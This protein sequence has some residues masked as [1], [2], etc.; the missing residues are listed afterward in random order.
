MPQ[1]TIHVGGRER[2]E[3]AISKATPLGALGTEALVWIGAT[4]IRGSAAALRALA[5]ALAEAA[6]LADDYDADPDAWNQREQTE[7][8]PTE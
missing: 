8:D 6:D 7:R 1:I 3:P 5:D 2:L 4:S